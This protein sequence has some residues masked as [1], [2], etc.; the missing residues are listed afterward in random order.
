MNNHKN[1]RSPSAS[2]I[3]RL[4]DEDSRDPHPRGEVE[5]VSTGEKR[6][7]IDYRSLVDLLDSWRRD[8]GIAS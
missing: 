6:F 4:W 3:V 1:L 7:F 5:Y 8:I 2:F